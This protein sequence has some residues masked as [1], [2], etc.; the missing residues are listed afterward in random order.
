MNRARSYALRALFT[1]ALAGMPSR[2]EMDDEIQTVEAVVVHTD[3]P[4]AR[5]TLPSPAADRAAE[6]G[7]AG[8]VVP[9]AA[10]EPPKAPPAAPPHPSIAAARDLYRALNKLEEGYGKK[11]TAR[12]CV[13]HGAAEPVKV[14][15]DKLDQ[16]AADVA[17]LLAVAT[18]RPRIEDLLATWEHAAKESGHV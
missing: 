17:K 11:L 7:A 1:D 6:R 12:L 14:P 2:E 9:P 8:E 3:P 4:P 5:T 13:L 15:A 10:V 18:D 16:F